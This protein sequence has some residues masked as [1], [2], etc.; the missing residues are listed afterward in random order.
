M[1]AALDDDLAEVLANITAA[2]GPDTHVI[3]VTPND[4]TAL[5]MLEVYLDALRNG[6]SFVPPRADGAKKPL[7]KWK[8]YQEHPPDVT[9]ATRW[10][11]GGCTGLCVICGPV[12]GNLEM[13]EAETADLYDDYARA[14]AQAGLAPLLERIE[15]G[16]SEMSPRGGIHLAYRVDGPEQ[17]HDC[18]PWHRHDDEPAGDETEETAQ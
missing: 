1:N 7:G 6:L 5:D 17:V 12:S 2:F 8:C 9:Q 3:D 13:L 11:R 14:L 15:A 18:P 10:A 4:P 16:Y